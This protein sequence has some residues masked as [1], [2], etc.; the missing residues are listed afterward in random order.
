MARWDPPYMLFIESS[1]ACMQTFRPVA[2]LFF[3]G[4]SSILDFYTEKGVAIYT[5]LR[6]SPGDTD[7]KY[8]WACGSTVQA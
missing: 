5:Y 1:C 7:S 6:R 4:K 8:I 2:P 3:S